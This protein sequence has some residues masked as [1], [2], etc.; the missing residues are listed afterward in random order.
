MSREKKKLDICSPLSGRVVPLDEVNDEV[1]SQRVLGDGCA[2]IPDEPTELLSPIDGVVTSVS[3]TNHAYSVEAEDKTQVLV[4]FGLE[5]VA[6]KGEGFTPTVKVGDKVKKGDK[7]CKIDLKLFKEK[8]IDLTTPV[9]I[10]DNPSGKNL[11]PVEGSVKAGEPL[12]KSKQTK[13]RSTAFDFLQKLGKVLMVVIAVMPAAGLMISIGKLIGMAG[14]DI[15]IISSIGS[16]TENIGWAIITNLHILFAV[17]I[18]GSWAKE[19]AGG[20]F[21]A[22]I[23]FILINNIT[24]SVFGVT[25]DMLLDDTAT[26]TSLLGKE[27][28]VTSYFTSVLGAP[29]LNMGVFVGI[30]S[31]FLGAIIYNKFYNFRRLPEALSFFGGKRFVPLVVI[32]W[33]VIVSLVM[34][35][36]WPIIQSGINSFGIWI[37]NSSQSSPV[38][39]PFIYGTLERLLLPFG[40]HHMLTIPM[41][42]TSFGGSY[43]ISTGANAGSVVFGQDPLWLAWITDLI[44]F[45]KNGDMTA[46]NQLLTQITPAR[47]KVGQMIGATGLL[48]GVALAMY[49]RVDR[50]KRRSY[51]SMFVST[52]L[53]VFLTGVT[54]PIEFM[55]MFCAIPLYIVYSLL[56]GCAFALSG[57]INLR[58]HSF[59]NLELATRIPMSVSAGL[60]GDII[61]FVISC[62]VFFLIGYLVAYYMI[63]RFSYATPGRLGNYTSGEETDS[64]S[65]SGKTGS[66]QTESIIALLGGRDNIELVDACMTRLRV[67]VR[68]PSLVADIDEWKKNGALGLLKKGNGVQAVYGPKADVI[69]SDIND[70]L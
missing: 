16:V 31:G 11:L 35:V 57:V 23:A 32:F 33:S 6:L 28:Q 70:I 15:G 5:T 7:L 53:A 21:A 58:L 43:I 27:M 56:Q 45:K 18:G 3:S 2:I 34:C 60:T 41:N 69:K 47:F 50:D 62:A 61:N 44:A 54:E 55:F 48:L 1:F 13:N 68:N 25:G 49:R 17:A 38:L 46:Y 65:S 24:G 29:A 42:Y 59:G 63:G 9:I 66:E 20:A 37:A 10:T 67:T 30:I 39:A 12:F 51:R 4:H 19:K 64:D 26:V 36:I 8:N 52:A 22:L 14:A 40:L